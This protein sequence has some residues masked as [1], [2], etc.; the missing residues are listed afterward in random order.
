LIEINTGARREAS[1]A[2]AIPTVVL[3]AT[4]DRGG[5]ID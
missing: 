3:A 1:V 5:G 2:S 4:I